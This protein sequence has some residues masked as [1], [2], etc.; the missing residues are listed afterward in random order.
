MCLKKHILYDF[1][2]FQN[3][4]DTLQ[5]E[6]H[7]KSTSICLE[8][9]GSLCLGLLCFIILF[10]YSHNICEVLTFSFTVN[11]LLK[12]IVYYYCCHKTVDDNLKSPCPETN[13]R[14][15]LN[16]YVNLNLLNQQNSDNNF[17]SNYSYLSVKNLFIVLINLTVS[18]RKKFYGVYKWLYRLRQCNTVLSKFMVGSQSKKL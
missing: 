18:L 7:E 3:R 9:N 8:S 17:H 16:K 12:S 2:F 11:T 4:K 15:K 13:E 10:Y 6:E 1:L 14:L 5:A